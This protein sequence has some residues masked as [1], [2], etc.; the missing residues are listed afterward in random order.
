MA[1]EPSPEALG[2]VEPRPAEPPD[3][4]QTA[5]L[6]WTPPAGDRP[7]PPPPTPA[8]PAAARPPAAT[9]RR[10]VLLGSLVGA[11]VGALVAGGVV[12]AFGSGS[13]T[14][15]T[16]VVAA[17]PG[18]L[19]GRPS[20]QIPT[21]ADIAS[22]VAK[23]EPA[24]VA[25]T[26]GGGPSSANGDAGTGFVISSDGYIATNNHVV[27]QGSVQVQLHDGRLVPARVVGHDVST[28]LA[29]LKVN[30][31]GLPAVQLGDSNAVQIGDAVVAIGNALA[32]EG[33]LSVTNGIISG[34]HRRVP[35]QNGAVL[36][37]M[38]Q[39]DA[40]INPGN[41]GGPLLDAQARVI[42]I[43]T[44]IANPG[45]AQNIGFAIPISRAVPVFDDLRN[46]RKP[47]FLG[48]STTDI[49]PQIASQ[50][51]LTVTQGALVTQVTSGTPAAAAGIRRNDVI[52]QI[53]T[54]TIATSADVQTVVRAQQPGTTVTV[55][56][57]RGG[58][59]QSLRAKLVA[60]PD[61]P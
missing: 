56:V 42:G 3:G 12:A 38:L 5:P 60:R 44:A 41:S 27:E 51:G 49:S 10:G 23:A 32:L 59:R 18:T 16:R 50:L 2:T 36:V 30:A 15:V 34:L 43:N 33:G 58:Q 26:A 20:T 22:I 55:V 48:V 40:A 47:A 31:S 46:G 21:G 6:R 8:A 52:V 24:I 1:D 54:A 19:V 7:P 35:E 9:T 11:L 13:T 14:T 45:V 57:V 4:D 39:T 29:V 17:P 61:S 28:D 37:D 53:G 25:V